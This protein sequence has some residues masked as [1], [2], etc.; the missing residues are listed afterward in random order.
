MFKKLMF[1]LIFTIVLVGACSAA[2]QTK[3][4]AP[5][6]FEDI[7]DGVFVLYD[8]FKNAD[9]ILSIVKFNQHDWKDYTTN[10]TENNY[11]VIKDKN[12]TYNYTDKSVNEKGS[13]ELI[14]IGKDKYIID[15]SKVGL[16][17]DYSETYNNLLEFNRINN[18]TPI[19]G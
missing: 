12:N 18:A 15:F 3:F 4:N 5:E 2:E 7:G 14:K 11:T 13:F 17:T 6:D 8:S 1:F 19:K 9:E 10:D 16:D